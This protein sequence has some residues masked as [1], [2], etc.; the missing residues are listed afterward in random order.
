MLITDRAQKLSVAAQ[1][2]GQHLAGEQQDQRLVDALK[3]LDGFQVAV[4]RALTLYLEAD[5]R[6]VDT[7]SGQPAVIKTA[8]KD[9][10][11]LRR[12][13]A[14]EDVGATVLNRKPYENARSSGEKAVAHLERLARDCW[15]RAFAE[16]FPDGLEDVRVPDLPGITSQV[17]RVRSLSARARA[18]ATSPFPELD[19]G[20]TAAT[21]FD[22]L[23]QLS[24][25][26]VEARQ[27][28][29]TA[30]GDIPPDVRAFI[31]AAG[32]EEGAPLSLLTDS[33]RA[34]L[35]QHHKL[36]GY[37]AVLR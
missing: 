25:E 21:L 34:W 20:E 33:V 23:D 26:L 14:K 18:L 22:R 11:A 27:H 29:E 6:S 12:E 7:P 8:Q 37:R 30:L 1:A 35:Q 24:A 9:A 19:G 28:L 2:Y 31:D 15:D 3:R 4:R 10:K 17:V 32:S 13:L 16:K 36:D 5:R